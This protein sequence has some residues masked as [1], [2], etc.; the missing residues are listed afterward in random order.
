MRLFY[1]VVLALTFSFTFHGFSYLLLT[2]EWKKMILLMHGQKV[3]SGLML[4]HNSYIMHITSSHHI[5]I[6]SSH[7]ITIQYNSGTPHFIVLH[8]MALHICLFYKLKVCGSPVSSQSTDAI[9]QQHLLTLCLF[10][11]FWQFLKYLK[12]LIIIV[13]LIMI[14]DL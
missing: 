11:I 7:I 1:T 6:S 13:F 10:V 12:L 2:A 3:K 9:F 14:C 4:C 5:G 8:Y